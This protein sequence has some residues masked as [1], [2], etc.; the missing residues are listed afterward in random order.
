MRW[1]FVGK[2]GRVITAW[3]VAVSAVLVFFPTAWAGGQK[4]PLSPLGQAG[5][6]ASW[7]TPAHPAGLAAR[8]PQRTYS[9]IP[10]I[11]FPQEPNPYGYDLPEGI[12]VSPRGNIYAGMN[13]S[14]QIYRIARDGSVAEIADFSDRCDDACVL[15]LAVDREERVYVC[16]WGFNVPELN[17]LWRIDPDGTKT[18]IIQFPDGGWAC[19]PNAMAF[20]PDGS[21]Y[22]TDSGSGSI[23]SLNKD[24]DH[25]VWLQDPLLLGDYFGANG[26]A[27]RNHSLWVLNYDRGRIVR[28]PIERDGTPGR[29]ETFV[30]SPLLVG[31]DGG[32]FD[33]L[34]NMYIGVMAQNQ[35]VRVS[36]RGKVDVLITE[37]EFAGLT[38]PINPVFGFGRNRSTIFLTGLNPHIVKIH[39]GIP[40]RLLEQFV[41]RGCSAE[42]GEMPVAPEE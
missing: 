14:G 7:I 42:G 5:E 6:N 16:V 38:M 3:T 21:L 33:V 17:A 22:I 32:Q 11:D 20:G 28:V 35:L 41:P 9:P 23:W 26:I 34:G 4:K 8:R 13:I 2:G 25:A 40:G 18:R 37:E 19:I 27:Y 29:P 12:A 24:G 10:V 30:E 36:P 15:G 1:N 39:V 31:C